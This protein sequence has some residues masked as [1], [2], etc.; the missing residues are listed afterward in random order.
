MIEG[1]GV[2]RDSH[3]PMEAPEFHGLTFVVATSRTPRD[4]SAPLRA[5]VE[6]PIFRQSAGPVPLRTRPITKVILGRV[7]IR[8]MIQKVSKSEGFRG[9]DFP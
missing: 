1:R 9:F 3:E 6:H 4:P 5:A 7:R 2:K 8:G